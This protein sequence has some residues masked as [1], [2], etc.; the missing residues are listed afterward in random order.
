MKFPAYWS[1]A[2][3]EEKDGF[4]K[5]VRFSCWRWS[6]VS[7]DD[8]Q[9]S[10]LA[11]ARRIVQTLIAGDPLDRY[12]Y[13]SRPLRE[14]VM[15]QFDAAT[16]EPLAA[17][18]QNAYGALV[19]NT[20]RVLFA[21]V[22]FAP[23]SAGQQIGHF[24][25]RWFDRTARPP[26]EVVRQETYER[27]RKFADDHQRWTAR[28]YRT[29]SGYRLLAT[30]DLFDPTGD[31][32]AAAFDRLGVDPLYRRLCREQESFRARL[33]PKPWRCGHTANTIPWPRDEQ[34]Q[35]DFDAWNARYVERQASFATCRLEE[36]FGAGHAHPEAQQV[37]ELH[38]RLTRAEEELALA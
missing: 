38:D 11:A 17:I 36:T 4:G 31:A 15:Q 14:P 13:G 1:R 3:V 12:G 33:T 22:D 10:A 18:T 32:T 8:A 29:H 24:F 7:Q 9:Q 21:D 27:I 28:L 2:T 5:P 25:K 19:L 6:N 37:V 20:A 34:Q 23:V 30:H 16:G 26:G 35:R